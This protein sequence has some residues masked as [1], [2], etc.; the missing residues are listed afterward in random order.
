MTLSCSYIEGEAITINIIFFLSMD[1]GSGKPVCPTEDVNFKKP[2]SSGRVNI[3]ARKVAD[4]IR[5]FKYF[6]FI[7]ITDS[8]TI[9]EGFF[10]CF[11]FF[12]FLTQI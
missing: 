9:Q 8:S 2:R 5:I 6:Y 12:I 3:N 11:F 1:S 4:K 10:I 7:I